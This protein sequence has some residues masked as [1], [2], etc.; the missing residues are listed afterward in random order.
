MVRNSSREGW[1][2]EGQRAFNHQLRRR[3]WTI[4]KHTDTDM[5]QTGPT[6]SHSRTRCSFHS[7]QWPHGRFFCLIWFATLLIV[8]GKATGHR[9][10]QRNLE[11]FFCSVDQD[12]NG[13]IERVEATK[14]LK[15]LNT[16]LVEKYGNG[17]K[18][19]SSDLFISNQFEAFSYGGTTISS[20]E[21][22]DHLQNM[23]TANHVVD[24][25]IHGLQLP[26]YAEAFRQNAIMGLDFPALI[27]NE[28][29]A[30]GE[31][32]GVNSL[33][34]RTKITRAIVHQVF[35]IGATPG[36]PL[37][38]MCTPSNCGGI[39]L[40]WEVPPVRGS[41]PLHK[42]LVQRWNMS[43]STW[44]QVADTQENSFFD[45]GSLIP[46]KTFSYR[47]QSWGGHGPSKWISTDG[48]IA[49]ENQLLA[50]PVHAPSDTVGLTLQPPQPQEADCVAK[51]QDEQ[52]IPDN[53]INSTFTWQ[54]STIFLL[55]AV[56]SRHAL[57]F[58]VTFAAW[59]LLKKKMWM[60][61]C[62]AIESDYLWLR[63]LARS[64]VMAWESWRYVQEKIWTLSRTGVQSTI[65]LQQP[66]LDPKP[67]QPLIPLSSSELE[68][69]RK[70]PISHSSSADSLNG[71]N[72]SFPSLPP[73]EMSGSSPSRTELG[74]ETDDEIDKKSVAAPT[75]PQL[76]EPA[77]I[78][79]KH[80]CNHDGCK[81]RFDRWHS[82]QDW[83]MKFNNHYCR[84]CQRVFCVRHTRIS[85]HGARGQC[86]LDSNCYCYT[87]FASLPS[88]SKRKLEDVNRL[89]FG[90]LASANDHSFRWPSLTISSRSRG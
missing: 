48:C 43:S 25:V 62:Q 80:R 4:G 71:V 12:G 77:P 52:H 51:T 38:L 10:L 90:P 86:G 88:D 82:V 5:R 16:R 37:G 29:R 73:T 76:E 78:R 21:M 87:C 58:D 6:L 24:W 85:P 50:S 56:L 9:G 74:T 28:S 75:S 61:L 46:G 35:G 89:R 72:A 2:M 70:L 54:N 39:Q 64:L 57:F 30:L 40:N 8:F 31:E 34:H 47:V 15:S 44:I 63:T 32:L 67:V 23:M 69:I 13:E 36:S 11:D 60:I 19:G 66:L 18:E 3:L 27:E 1:L 59:V 7:D 45:T 79:S 55:V 33:F 65:G 49:G 14:F 17:A 53:E 26:Q 84:E 20:E 42:Y 83:W 68:Y 81:T 41:P 22:M